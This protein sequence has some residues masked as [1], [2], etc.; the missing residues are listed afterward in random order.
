MKWLT[1]EV[2]NVA[3]DEHLPSFVASEK[4]M[5]LFAKPRKHCGFDAQWQAERETEMCQE[6]PLSGRV[7]MNKGR[8]GK[9]IP[10]ATWKKQTNLKLEIVFR[11]SL[12]KSTCPNCFIK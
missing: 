7:E 8:A 11:A 12:I 9:G 1:D 3:A 4:L 2:M 10:A 6:A 5:Q